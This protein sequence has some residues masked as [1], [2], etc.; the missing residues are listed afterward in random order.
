MDNVQNMHKLPMTHSSLE[1]FM[2][3]ISLQIMTKKEDIFKI[4]F[5]TL[6]ENIT[7][8][9]ISNLMTPEHTILRKTIESE[10]YPFDSEI[11]SNNGEKVEKSQK[12]EK[13]A[14]GFEKQGNPLAYTCKISHDTKSKEFL[15]NLEQ[16]SLVNEVRL[17]FQNLKQKAYKFDV[18]LYG[19]HNEKETLLFSSSYDESTYCYLTQNSYLSE[20]WLYQDNEEREAL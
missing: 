17:M 3:L 4:L 12:Q 15:I 16:T 6:Y 11:F 8:K 10:V 18:K 7:K 1:S 19:I 20:Y 9:A 14:E 5:E 13:G 2:T